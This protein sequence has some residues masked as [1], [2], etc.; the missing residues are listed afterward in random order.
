MTMLVYPSDVTFENEGGGV[1][2][3]AARPQSL[4]FS[5]LGI[6]VLGRGVA[7]YSGSIIDVFARLGVSEE[8]V[9][10]TLAR[11]TKR[12]LLTR[13]RR[14]RKAYFGLTP[15]A[16]Q[17]LEDGRRRV[18]D[19]GAAN[20]D[21]D[22]TWTAVAFSLPNDQGRT[23]HD[24]RSRL[25]WAGFAPLQGGLWI[26]PGTKDVTQALATLDLGDA[27]TVLQSKPMGPTDSADLVRRAFDIDAVA[28]RYQSFLEQWDGGWPQAAGAD[29]LARQILLHTD[30]L[31]VIRRDP[32][33]PAEHLPE[34]WP[35]I[36]AEQV[37]RLLDR[38]VAPGAARLAADLL[39][40]IEL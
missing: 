35:A 10:S 31:Q 17:V 34:E 11:M 29:N 22:G 5:F 4:M 14:G 24:L 16:T 26:A 39:D 28:A 8:A 37:F 13:H 21:W 33:L 32:H 2:A 36:R 30:W 20:R 23:R 40:E 12:N 27:V 38:K 1:A 25:T 19:T 3:A 7:V 9:R 18:H 15:H 6:Y